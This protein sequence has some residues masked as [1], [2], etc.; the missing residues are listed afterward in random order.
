MKQ[1]PDQLESLIG[2]KRFLQASLILVRSLETINKP[3]LRE[4][5]ALSDL[6][7]YFVTQ[8]TVKRKYRHME[9]S[10][11]IL[12]FDRRL[13]KSSLKNSTTTS[14]S[15]HFTATHDGDRIPLAEPISPSSNRKAA[16]TLPFSDPP[17]PIQP[18]PISTPP[19]P[20]TATLPPDQAHPPNSLATY[21]NSVPNRVRGRCSN[22]TA[23]PY[24]PL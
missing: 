17:I 8:E 18:L 11:D 20:P 9:Q 15:K 22:T 6:R 4:I 13:Q 19:P 21:P 2:D 23:I 1:V 10:T 7:S 16:T 12:T 5:G 24:R 14:T 3:E